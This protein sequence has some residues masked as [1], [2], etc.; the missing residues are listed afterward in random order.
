MLPLLL[1]GPGGT[2]RAEDRV[3]VELVL[4]VDISYSM[5]EDELR[6][7]RN[8]Y[9]EA[10][11]SAEAM[12]AIQRGPTR[13]IAVS[14]VEWAGAAEQKLVMDWTIIDGPESARDFAEKLLQQ[15]YRRAY[16]T[17]ISGAMLFSA[18]LFDRNPYRGLRQVI[19]I[20]GDG[21]NNQGIPVEDAREDVLKR[22]I[23]INGLPILIKR[24]GSM[25]MA[26]LDQ[27]YE[28]CVIGGEGSFMVPIKS[29]EQFAAAIRMKLIMEIAGNYEERPRV[30]PAA[31]ARNPLCMAG[32]R[33]W[34][35]R[36][37]W[38]RN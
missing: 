20:S 5:D 16:R 7:Q 6:L 28:E 25:D 10:I 35:E 34:Q 8:G 14:Y 27:Y 18:P 30:V 3:D 9:A 12:N 11:T 17:S 37:D 22:G 29:R 2:A 32:E 13:R 36:M 23:V 24:P 15:P 4:A 26:N 21:A 1:P 31:T 19:D 33:Q 38:M